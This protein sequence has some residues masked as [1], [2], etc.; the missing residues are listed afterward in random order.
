MIELGQVDY[1]N[2]GQKNCT[3]EIKIELKDSPKGKVLSIMGGIWNSKHSDYY[4]CGQCLDTIL[5]FF[6]SNPKVK[7]IVEIWNRWHLNDMKAGTPKQEACIR[8]MPTPKT[9]QA[10]YDLT[11][12]YLES[13]GLLVDNGYKYGSEWLFEE[14]PNEIIVEVESF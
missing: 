14:I 9:G 4:T 1:N 5:E 13:K 2:S 10:I 8:E 7:R 6:P 12:E 3:A 11:C